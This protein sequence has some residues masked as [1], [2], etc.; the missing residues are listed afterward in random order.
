M[1]GGEKGRLPREGWLQGGGREQARLVSL[2]QIRTGA[3]KWGEGVGRRTAGMI[4][5]PSALSHP[6]SVLLSLMILKQPS[7]LG[8]RPQEANH[9]G[10][11]TV[12]WRP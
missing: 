7:S 4:K 12:S 6:L 11:K 5:A 8:W 2:A 3:E 1:E 9:L 10:N